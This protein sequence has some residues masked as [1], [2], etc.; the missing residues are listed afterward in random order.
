MSS[1]TL[2]NKRFCACGCGQEVSGWNTHKKQPV[3]FKHGHNAVGFKFPLRRGPQGARWK[4]GKTIT[5]PG[6]ILLNARWDHPRSY[7]GRILEHIVVYEQY[8]KC[9]LLKWANVH[10]K[11]HN[12][13]DNRSENLEAM[14]IGQHTRL[15]MLIHRDS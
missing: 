14:M 7:R 3:R 6:Y 5:K 15:H 13:S 9:C 8:H 12:K 10:H 2:D 11:N 1:T 4:G